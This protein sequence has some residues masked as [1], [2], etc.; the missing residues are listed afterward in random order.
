MLRLRSNSV[1]RGRG[2]R[3]RTVMVAMEASG[4]GKGGANDGD[5]EGLDQGLLCNKCGDE[6]SEAKD[7]PV[8]QSSSQLSWPSLQS[9]TTSIALL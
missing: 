1:E 8:S 6:D 9:S 7:R 4:V 3:R 5:D 2:M